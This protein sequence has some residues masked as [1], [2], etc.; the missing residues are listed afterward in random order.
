MNFDDSFFDETIGE[1][2]VNH[3][4]FTTAR[5]YDIFQNRKELDKALETLQTKSFAGLRE[6]DAVFTQFFERARK[7]IALFV[8]AKKHP[9][10]SCYELRY[11]LEKAEE[12]FQKMKKIYN[13]NIIYFMTVDSN[14]KS[15]IRNY[16]KNIENLILLHSFDIKRM[17]D[18]CKECDEKN[19]DSYCSYF[20]NLRIF[21]SKWQDYKGRYTYYN[22]FPDTKFT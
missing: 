4:L 15:I 7:I 10:I 22:P 2:T 20:K 3:D 18:T 5:K 21:D 13:D 6:E 14:K 8:H 16:I 9:F 12:E 11:I 1:H 19:G 17:V